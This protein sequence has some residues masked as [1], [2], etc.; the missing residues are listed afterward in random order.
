MHGFN[1]NE[2]STV[3]LSNSICFAIAQINLYETEERSGM[4]LDTS[5]SHD[6]AITEPKF[7]RLNYSLSD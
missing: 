7:G 5:G 6:L 2:F 3:T 1:Q 4:P